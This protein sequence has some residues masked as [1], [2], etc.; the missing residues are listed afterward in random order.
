MQLQILQPYTNTNLYCFSSF[1]SPPKYS[2]TEGKQTLCRLKDACFIF[3]Y[4]RHWARM[5]QWWI[6]SREADGC[7]WSDDLMLH[8]IPML[9]NYYCLAYEKTESRSTAHSLPCKFTCTLNKYLKMLHP[10]SNGYKKSDH[11]F[12]GL[13]MFNF[14]EMTCRVELGKHFSS[15]H[16]TMQKEFKPKESCP[17]LMYSVKQQVYIHT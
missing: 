13:I 9:I 2:F 7:F 11:Q 10:I 5:L 4:R 1:P 14:P 17:L 8:H 6:T 16:Q 15:M 12:T 3:L